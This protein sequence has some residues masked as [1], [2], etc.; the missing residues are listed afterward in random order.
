MRVLHRYAEVRKID[1]LVYNLYD[2]NSDE[3]RLI[4]KQ[5]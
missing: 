2:L 3:I 4:E 5:K 1:V